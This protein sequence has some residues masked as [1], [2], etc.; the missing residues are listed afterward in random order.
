MLPPCP[1]N[2]IDWGK[3][4]GREENRGREEELEQGR[5]DD[6]LLLRKDENLAVMMMGPERGGKRM[7][8]ELRSHFIHHRHHQITS[9]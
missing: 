8:R 7:D 6:G 4:R 5:L 1:S 9:S 3:E 2:V